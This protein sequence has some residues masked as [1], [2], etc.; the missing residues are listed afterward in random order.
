L[1][2]LVYLESEECERAQERNDQ[3]TETD[4]LIR[5][6]KYLAQLTTS[7]SSFY[8]NVGLN[9]LL[10]S[11][12]TS[13]VQQ[14]YEFTTEHY[15]AS[16]K[17]RKIK[18]RLMNQLA[19]RFDGF[20]NI[21]T[22]EYGEL[23]F[24]TCEDQKRWVSLVEECLEAFIP[25]SSRDTCLRGSAEL[26]FG[27]P[28]AEVKHHSPPNH[29]DGIE[30][31][32]CHWFMHSPCYGELARQL[33]LDPPEERLSVPQFQ[34]KDSGVQDPDP[35]GARRKIA[36]LTEAEMQELR[37]RIDSSDAKRQLTLL[38]PLKIVA[39]GAVRA[40]LDPLRDEKRQ[41]E[42]HEGMKLLE[43]RTETA[44][45]DLTL[46]THWIDYTEWNGIAAGEYTIALKD[47]RQLRFT[48]VPAALGTAQEGGAT[49]VVESRS[50]SFLPAWSNFIGSYL[51]VRQNLPSYAFAFTLFLALGW[52][53]A[54]KNYRSKLAHQESTIEHLTAQ[55]A[56]QKTTVA[57]AEQKPSQ[58]AKIIATYFLASANPSLRGT[59]NPKEEVVTF[60]PGNSLVM[61]DL[62]VA[63][64]EN[65]SYRATLSSF[66]DEQELFR[67]NRLK[68]IQKRYGWVVEFALP[69]AH[70]RDRTH[71][72]VTLEIPDS[73]GRMAPVTRFLFEVRK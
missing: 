57:S 28:G 53:A 6:I 59:D 10:R 55:I 45:S 8:V 51:Q 11:Y 26:R 29:V 69:S 37:Q 16:E 38:Q 13:E 3:Q 1:Q 24:E 44:G 73:G 19:A 42:I 18:G 36:P 20:I 50:S 63:R 4:L 46:A 67:E 40:R 12:S 33:G 35:S 30:T 58:P 17:Y 25:W 23:K 65:G 70:V 54:T 60:A 39:H 41:F 5:Y 34:H 64:G 9:R 47:K 62:A 32:R 31:N 43:V 2:W 66:P 68:P 21:R 15:P 49:V 48:I 71:Y 14:V 72:L 7:A 61:L 56:S 27:D 52:L 22:S